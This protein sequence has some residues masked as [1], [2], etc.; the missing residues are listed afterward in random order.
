MEQRESNLNELEIPNKK[1][2][3][4][5][6]LSK[7]N[8]DGDAITHKSFKSSVSNSDA[9]ERRASIITAYFDNLKINL[10]K[11]I[12]CATFV[13]GCVAWM[14]DGEILD[15]LSKLNLGCSI[16]VQKED[17]LRPDIGADFN[18]KNNLR[19]KYDKLYSKCAKWRIPG[20]VTLDYKN[21][22]KYDG[23]MTRQTCQVASVRCMG[24]LNSD[25]NPAFPRM[26]NKFIVFCNMLQ[27]E[28]RDECDFRHPIFRNGEDLGI[29]KYINFS[30]Q[31][32]AVWTG[33]YNFTQNATQ[34]LE[35]AVFIRDEMIAKRYYDEWAFIYGL[36]E[37][38]DW[39]SK[40]I[41][42]EFR[43]GT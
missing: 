15:E 20:L 37:P 26:H 10:I 27:H 23:D 40:W 41:N 3:P 24:N 34:S 9:F 18:W 38:L 14:T 12:Q 16:V 28:D 30:I 25:R 29:E 19:K 6:Y 1:Y 22:N 33:S 31:P 4:N 35:N 42:P 32:Y 21:G 13:V 17:F 7:C 36:S 5:T 2:M 11:H 43:I 39:T 8:A